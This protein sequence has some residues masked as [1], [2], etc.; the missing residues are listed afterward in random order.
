MQEL[1]ETTSR[2]VNNATGGC[3]SRELPGEHRPRE[4]WSV[5]SYGRRRGLRPVSPYVI[6]LA[7]AVALT[8]SF[9]LPTRAEAAFSDHTVTTISPSGTTINLFDYWVNPDNHL[10]VS[11]NGGVN[12]NH[13]FQFNDGQGGE[14]LNHWTGNTNPQPGIVNNTLLDG[15]PQLSKTWGGESLCYLFDSSAQIGKTSHF[16][17]TGLLKVQN[18]YYVYDS[19]KNY[20]AYNADK[21]AFDIYDTWGIDKVGDSSHQGQFFPFD[22]ADKVLKEENGRLVQTGIKADNT[23]DSRYNDGRPVNHH[24]GLSM[25]TRFVQPAGGK[26]NAGDDMVFEFA[27]DDDVWVFIDDVL[28]GDIGGIHNRAS[29]SINFCTGDIKVNGNNDGTLKNK[30]Q[31]ANK[32]TSG[33]NG[34][35]FADG[36]NHTL[37]FFY[38]ERGATDSNMEL[39]FNLV[40]V[41]ES[42]IIKFDQDGKFVQ[43]AEFKLYKTDKDFKT[44]GELIGSGTTDEAGHL[45]LTN[46]VDNG[47]INFDDLYNKD[48][49]NNKYYLLKET[50]VP[51]GYRS[52]L[53]ATGGSMQLEY[54][55][56]SAENG[57]GGVIINRGGMDAGSVV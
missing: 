16:G 35:T 17:V 34:Y 57:A 54:V 48:H 38:L 3:L 26:T 53:A 13:R 49:D 33:F 9:F 2:L 55:P 12:A 8:A 56:A 23:G 7:L 24:F 20:A 40:T 36:T 29:L 27:G 15:Y 11:G 28:V 18:G 45:T 44:V 5:M 50:R 19:S 43:G 51:D 25:S 22:A 37:K 4:R 1:R 42:D 46:D 47:V 32:D 31:N 30:Y 10:S 52:S 6:V 14:S 41:P 21:N 39:K